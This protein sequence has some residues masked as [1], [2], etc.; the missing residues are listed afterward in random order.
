M[1]LCE[2]HP[3]ITKALASNTLQLWQLPTTLRDL[4]FLGEHYGYLQGLQVAHGRLEELEAE[5]D[6]LFGLAA[7]GSFTRHLPKQGASFAELCRLRGDNALAEAVE[8]DWK[9]LLED[10]DLSRTEL[11]KDRL[12]LARTKEAN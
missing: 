12:N 9:L 1:C 3:D 8:A 6:R 10:R 5:C 11:I 2:T 4:Y 7:Q